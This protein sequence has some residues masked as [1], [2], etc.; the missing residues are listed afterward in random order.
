M[1]SPK[2]AREK[3]SG[4][5]AG[6]AGWLALLLL[7]GPFDL[8]GQNPAASPQQKPS[9]KAKRVWTEDD[10][11]TLRKPWDLY[12]IAQE[13]KAAEEKAAR[14]AEE[15]AKKSAPKPAEPG[16]ARAPAAEGAP[17]TPETIPALEDRVF[18]ARKKVAALEQKLQDAERAAY[19]SREDERAAALQAQE[20]VAQELEK[21]RSE[22]KLLEDKLQALKAAQSNESPSP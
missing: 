11:V 7:F 19:D 6:C 3:S 10:L 5:R 13:K 9:S 20:A 1:R 15:A 2:A 4:R 18:E 17:P 22:L 16:A 8:A 12:V 21:A 14:E